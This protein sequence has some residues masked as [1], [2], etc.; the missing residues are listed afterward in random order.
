MAYIAVLGAANVDIGGFVEGRVVAE[1]SNPGKVRLSM[2]GVGRNIACNAA[3]MGA[4]VELVTAL[5]GDGYADMIRAD[6]ARAG[7]GLT[8]AIGFPEENTSTYLFIAGG[9]GDMTV[10]VNDMGIHDRMTVGR[11]RPLLSELN[12][13]DLVVIEANPPEETIRFLA[14]NLT[15][16]V[17]ADAVSA[18]KVMKLKGALPHLDAFKPNRIEAELL[19]G[20]AVSDEASARRACKAMLDMGVRRVFL[21]MG[22][23]GVCCGEGDELLFL[24][25]VPVEMR[26][27]TGAGD[28]F[29]AALAWARTQGLS[30]RESALAGMAAA[31]VAVQSVETVSNEMSEALL[32][33]R[34]AEIERDM[35]GRA[36]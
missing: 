12:R 1:D 32:R 13:A 18:A 28:A 27:A 29:T 26:N 17:I 23:H 8:H 35:G 24:P 5:G 34:M 16:P 15:V 36:Q 4:R 22:T 21:T 6:C 7:V 33:R 10:A 19:T 30:L 14:E 3:R 31:S 20:V 2:G 11:V 25:G 9:D